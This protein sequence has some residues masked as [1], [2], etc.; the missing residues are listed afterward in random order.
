M[1]LESPR[2]RL[3]VL[4][5]V[6]ISLFAALAARAWYLQVIL[7]P[8]ARLEVN[9]NRVRTVQLEAPRGRILDRRGRVLVDNRVFSAVVVSRSELAR[10]HTTVLAHLSSLLDVPLPTLQRRAADVRFSPFRPVPVATD[11]PKDKLIYMREHAPDFPGVDVVELTERTYP[12]GALGAHVL[13]YVGQIN[14]AELAARRSKGYKL[15]DT[16]GKS[17][18][19][20]V[21]E[22]DLR[23]NPGVQQLEVDVKGRVLRTLASRPPQQGHDVQLTIDADVQRL[24]EESL[25]EGLNVDRTVWDQQA[26]KHFLAP[27]G[28]LVVLDPRD[29]S[30]LA[31][32]SNPSYDP[33]QFVNGIKPEVFAALQDPQSHFPLNNRAIQGLYAPGSTFKLVT[34]LAALTKGLITPHTTVNDVGYVRIGNEIKQNAGREVHG[35]VDL[36][37]ALTVSS[38]VYFY[39]LGNQFWNQRRQFGDAIQEEAR[40]LGMGAPTGVGLSFEAAGRVPDPESRRRLHDRNPVAFPNGDW[41]AGDNANLAIGQ[42]ELVVTPLQLAN[43]YAT[44]ANG[45]TVYAPRVAARVLTSDGQVVREI[46]PKPV[47]TVAMPDRDAVLA[48]LRGVTSDPAGTAAGAFA[49]FDQSGVAVAAKT[50]TAQVTGKQDTALFTAF[51]PADAPRWVVTVV[52]EEGGFGADAAAPVARR[53][54]EGLTGRKPG[55]INIVPAKHD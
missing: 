54:L 19:E 14:D 52:M 38:D 4:G 23:G 31:M 3:G 8:Q 11:V 44:F 9:G 46:S 40:A 53:V 55:P 7:A 32:A 51:A 47:R 42:G 15:G 24:A 1:T 35:L 49:G 10:R 37:R 21:Y 28:A 17:G 29:G 5:V 39:L 34:T 30:V 18:V 22:E 25:A 50:G 45:G 13:G 33:A 43:S 2:L 41:F 20:L 6:V 16:L 36:P 48:G 26:K 12:M 27:A